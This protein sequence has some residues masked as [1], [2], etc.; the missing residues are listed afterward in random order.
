MAYRLVD[1]IKKHRI[2]DNIIVESF[3]PIILSAIR[4]YSRDIML[5]YNFADNT[6]AFGEESQEQFNKIPWILKQHWVQKQVR[7]IVRPDILGARFNLRPKIL[8]NLISKGYPVISWTVDDLET[9]KLLYKSGV[10]GL[11]SNKPQLIEKIVQ[12]KYKKILDAGGSYEFVDTMI[13]VKD[14]EDIKN[15]IKQ[16]KKEGKKISIGGRRH[17]MGGQTIYKDAIFIDML[18]FNKVNYNPE[19]QTVTAQSGAT[20]KKIQEILANHGRSVKIMQSDN[21][22]TVGGSIGVNVHGWQVNAA[23]I[24]STILRMTVM[25]ADRKVQ[26]ISPSINPELFNAV[27]GGYGMFAIILDAELETV[28]NTI[29]KFN[30]EFKK[31]DNLEEFFERNINKNPKAELAYARF[32]MDK[33]N[34]LD[35]AGVFWYESQESKAQ[36]GEINPEKLIAFKR[37]IF[38]ISEYS[39]LGKKIRWYLEKKYTEY[40]A[41]KENLLIRSDAMNTDI[42]ILWPLYGNNKD[43]LHEYF[44]PKGHLHSF[45]KKLKERVEAYNINITN[46]TLRVVKKDTTSLLPYA[47]QDMYALVC[48]FSQNKTIEGEN[49]MK[50][51]TQNVI[52]DSISFGGSFYLPYRLHYTGNQILSAYPEIKKWIILKK[53]YDP[54]FMLYSQFF[55][56]IQHI[57]ENR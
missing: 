16:A 42:H 7:R 11:Q 18:N 20:W 55:D 23:P 21:I 3:N 50:K 47:K 53:K 51:F 44:I 28:P 57:L 30:A 10:K 40:L 33:S 1:C 43:I 26:T 2:Q 48:F 24:S 36:I 25:T 52:E 15:G 35:E 29:V 22:F 27:T 4:L 13:K 56:Y 41:K 37:S 19:T 32:S 5:M 12:K 54:D 45:I 31:T 39:N 46:V 6:T 8:K 49:K 38:R 17:S 9:A 14:I 34:L